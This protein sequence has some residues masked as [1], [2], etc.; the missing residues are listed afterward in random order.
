MSTIQSSTSRIASVLCIGA[1][2][3]TQTLISQT[4][5]SKPLRLDEKWWNHEIHDDERQ[6]FLAGYLNCRQFRHAVPAT[7]VDYESF[8]RDH[9]SDKANSVPEMIEIASRRM[10][11]RNFPKGG[12]V[13]PGP[14]GFLDGGYWGS[15][16]VQRGWIEL[17]RGFVEGYL[18]CLRLPVTPSSVDH[19][20]QE[21]DRHYA[22]EAR[23]HDFIADVLKRLLAKEV[24]AI[25]R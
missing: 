17:Q 5:D 23:E 24:Q 14:H 7:Y 19:Y 3:F 16:P 1:C 22:D 10:K 13:W 6:G 15:G 25:S 12:E 4:V 8:V 21:L 20:V 11:P 18:S 2:L 9:V